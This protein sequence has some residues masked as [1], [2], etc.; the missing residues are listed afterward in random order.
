M[1]NSTI[2]N[3]G[4]E[5]SSPGLQ[6]LVAAFCKYDS[7]ENTNVFQLC[8][9]YRGDELDTEDEVVESTGR[10]QQRHEDVVRQ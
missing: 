4:I 5:N 2:P 1:G 3:P 10:L 8:T 9:A 6:S 7:V